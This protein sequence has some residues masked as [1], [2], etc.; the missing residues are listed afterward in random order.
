VLLVFAVRDQGEL[1]EEQI[2]RSFQAIQGNGTA[3]ATATLLSAAICIPLILGIIK[4]KSGAALRDYL[5]LNA[6]PIKTVL[7][8]LAIL[9]AFLAASDF[10]TIFLG[11]P[12]VPEFMTEI[13]PSARPIWLMWLALVVVA[14]LLEEIY[15]RGF[16]F[17]GLA[18]GPI[19]PI[20]AIVATAILWA[21]IH[22]QYDVYGIATIFFQGLLAGAARLKTGS[23]TVPVLMHAEANLIAAFETVLVLR[24]T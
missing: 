20:G 6:V 24:L 17:K 18:A 9:T 13:Y 7:L 16:L 22:I 21:L 12:L 5:A 10:L 1:S 23:L 3:F 14:P 4:L 8:W 2:A 15:F 11:R 19:G